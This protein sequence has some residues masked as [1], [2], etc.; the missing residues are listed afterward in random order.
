VRFRPREKRDLAKQSK[1]SS[2]G[3][4]STRANEDG[5]VRAWATSQSSTEDE[6]DLNGYLVHRH[7]TQ[8][9]TGTVFFTPAV[10]R[11]PVFPFF[12]EPF[13]PSSRQIKA[14]HRLG[15]R[16]RGTHHLLSEK[17]RAS[18]MTTPQPPPPQRFT[19]ELRWACRER[20]DDVVAHKFTK[21]LASGKI[22]RE[23]LGRYLVQDYRFLDSFVVLLS[24]VVANAHTL[25]DRI[26]GCQFLAVITGKENTY[27]E[28]AFRKLNIS[29]EDREKVPDAEC[30]TGF[31]RL[32][33]D[34]ARHGTLAEML[35]VLVV[36][37]WSYLSWAQLL[38]R[39]EKER[40][41][42]NS[43]DDFV[44]YEWI[45]LHSG[46]FFEGVVE[47]V[48]DMLDREGLAI[49]EEEKRSCHERFQRAVQLELDFFDYAYSS[50]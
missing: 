10:R 2:E 48:R 9:R 6:E 45:E 33:V 44:T 50:E 31:C 40:N 26:P 41:V 22:R 30:T 34:A 19:D 15:Q 5:D 13:S 7:A 38:L 35:S 46:E 8:A 49:G 4:P 42:P 1:A 14:R 32:M 16:H 17:S 36:C 27:F 39:D 47:Y 37:E 29:E 25:D 12:V 28:R 11:W 18:E 20:W 23:V 3:A 43:R 21:E 24:S